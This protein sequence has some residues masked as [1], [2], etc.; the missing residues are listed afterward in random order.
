MIRRKRK[1]IVKVVVI[2]HYPS[3]LRGF[4]AA[5]E[6][7][8]RVA[9]GWGQLVL[10][11]SAQRLQKDDEQGLREAVETAGCVVVDLMRSDPEWYDFLAPVLER[12]QGHLLAFGIQF[13]ERARLGAFM[14]PSDG[15]PGLP[16]GGFQPPGASCRPM[17]VGQD[18]GEPDDLLARRDALTYSQLSHAYRTMRGDDALFVLGSLLRDYGNQ[19]GLEVPAASPRTTGVHLADPA[20]RTRFANSADYIAAQGAPD[21]RPVVA[22]LYNGSGYPTDPEPTAAEIAHALAEH[23]WV[24]PIS[25]ETDA[26]TAVD[27]ILEICGAP[28]FEP[29]LIV[30]LMSFRFGAGPMGGDADH[31]V[32][33]LNRLGAPYLSPIL[34]TRTTA[35]EWAASHGLGP[36]EVLVS[37]MLPEFDGAINQIPVAAMTPSRRDARHRTATGELRVIDEQLSRLKGRISGLLRLR[38]LVN[39]DK[40]VAIIGYD[41]PAG[42]GNLLAASQL[43]VA[44][45]IAAILGELDRQGYQTEPISAE[46][47][48]ADLEAGQVNS[49]AYLTAVQCTRYPHQQAHSD[50]GD[51]VAWQEVTRAWPAGGSLPMVDTTGDY[52]IPHVTY[53][54]VLVGVQPGRAFKVDDALAHD[55]TVPPHPQYLAY[56]TWLQ[57]VWRA[58]VIV[59]VGTHGT[60]EFLKSKEN[61]VSVHDYPDLMVGDV[62][63]VYLYYVGN[64][65]EALIARRRAHATLV[66]YQPPVMTP[67]GLHSGLAELAEALAAYRRSLAMTPHTSADLLADL[68]E[69]AKQAHLPDD[70]DQLE[71]ELERL[72][73]QLIPLGLH[74]FGRAWDC[75]EIGYMVSGM[76]SNGVAEV[77][78]GYELLAAADG[79]GQGQIRQLSEAEIARYDA[80]AK[81]LVDAALASDVPVEEFAGDETARR[82]MT[83][84][85]RLAIRLAS[86]QEWEFLHRA[87]SGRHVEARLGGDAIRDPE[88]LPSGASLYQFDPRQ[89]PSALAIRRGADMARQIVNT[90]KATH[91]G[92]RPSCVGLVLWGLETTRTHGETYAQVMA[93]IGVRRARARRPGQPGWEVIPTTELSG[94]RV[95]VVVTISGFFRDLFGTLVE[96]LDDMFA[97]VA[98]LDEPAE[99]NPIAARTRATHDRLIADGMTKSQARELSHVRVFGPP[100]ELYATGLTDVIDTGNWVTTAEL[101]EHFTHGAQHVYSRHRHG[102]RVSGLYRRHLA[103]VELVAQCRSSNEHHITDLD[104][105]FEFLGGMSA[106]VAAARG[107][108]VPT[109]VTDTT[110]RRVHTATAAEASRAG[111][112]AQLLNPQ[113]IEAMLAHG[114]QGVGE[115]ADRITNLLGLAATTG[116]ISDWMFDAVC[117]RFLRDQEMLERLRQVNPHATAAIA[118]RLLEA[119]RRELWRADDE[120]VEALENIQF[121]IDARLEGIE[122]ADT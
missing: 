7:Y 107:E 51:A 70:P 71:G 102:E 62:P 39:R 69:R 3:A 78:P 5:A 84:A 50:L 24:L 93:L 81:R 79:L 63:H 92:M 2:T 41:Y 12:F 116:E 26:A 85:R 57:R 101:A 99:I 45:S 64:P 10:F 90:Y 35:D 9:P 117:D 83:Q 30:T 13:A 68:R 17:S 115:I 109:L 67:G 42:E 37:V 44:E 66:S 110:G 87:L 112:Y 91:D 14:M 53:G 23:A 21:G 16:L 40:R 74:V 29:E 105:F 52:L 61:A 121:D 80:E 38:H 88:V 33:A 72:R 100:P 54:N 46:R 48:R 73:A 58:D 32:A 34:L 18:S 98:A 114:H 59:H 108:S 89:V 96:E 60:L 31:G 8:D 25:I 103:D 36:S 113:W 97:A 4:I 20:T 82:I 77:P 122:E 6:H 43:D 28:G 55:N 94:S 11:D 106:S 56:Y 15:M 95:D 120:R 118:S 65:A 75:E 119:G 111:L 22:L 86:N 27:P 76:I 1:A 19:P 104:H 47:L 49:P